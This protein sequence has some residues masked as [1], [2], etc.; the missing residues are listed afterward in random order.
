MDGVVRICPFAPRGDDRSEIPAVR[1][2]PFNNVGR[3][4]EQKSNDIIRYF[5]TE[6]YFVSILKIAIQL[7]RLFLM[8]GS[9]YF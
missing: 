9:L 7:I 2:S 8:M 6:L 5:E 4:N 1:K 3:M